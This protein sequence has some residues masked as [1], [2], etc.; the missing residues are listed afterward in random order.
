M[1]ML[2]DRL[3]TYSKDQTSLRDKYEKHRE[4]WED[5]RSDLDRLFLML[6]QLPERWHEY[7]QK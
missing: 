2:G 3:I 6:Q 4:E 7:N 1:K 5:L